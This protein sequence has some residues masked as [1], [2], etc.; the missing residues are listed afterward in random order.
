MRTRRLLALAALT[1]TGGFGV[2]TA[3]RPSMRVTVSQSAHA[4][5]SGAFL[6]RTF[7]GWRL[8][9]INI[10]QTGQP[11]ILVDQNQLS[12]TCVNHVYYSCP[13]RPD[14][15][16]MPVA[17]NPRT[18]SFG[19]LQNYFFDPASFTDN[20]IGTLGNAT[21]NFFDGPGFWNTDFS[22]Q[23]DTH[24][25]ERTSFQM[26]LEA[27]NLFNHTNFAN[28]VGDVSS[29]NFGRITGIRLGS[30][31]RLVQLGAKFIF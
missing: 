28:P 25:T 27:Y 14:L 5:S 20:T 7:S 11:I 4:L 10:L 22:V 2:I 19:G 24:I 18:A 31:S 17:L 6:N 29:G 13:D 30:N 21:R 12:L 23:K 1:H 9:G 3:T 8:S 26:R 16:S 15:V